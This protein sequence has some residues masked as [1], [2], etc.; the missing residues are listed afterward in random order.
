LIDRENAVYS[1]TDQIGSRPLYHATEASLKIVSNSFQFLVEFLKKRSDKISLDERSAYLLLTYGYVFDTATIF[2]EVRRLAVGDYML[3]TINQ[4]KFD[5][6]YRIENTPKSSSEADAIDG[7]DYY[8]RKAVQLAFEK[9]KEYNYEHLVSLS[10]GLDS[11]MTSW[12]A[13]ELGFTKSSQR[14]ILAKQLL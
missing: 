12:V 9:D 6:Y 3:T 2:N 11:R 14:D 10:G 13:H 4:I 5:T 1:F 7:I 8:F